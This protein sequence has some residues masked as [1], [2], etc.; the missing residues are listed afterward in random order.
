MEAGDPG[1]KKGGG[2]SM[3]GD[4]ESAAGCWIN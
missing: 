3:E 4:G 1:K 2:R